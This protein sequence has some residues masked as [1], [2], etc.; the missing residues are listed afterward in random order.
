M[1][2]LRL[3]VMDIMH[4]FAVFLAPDEVYSYR[5]NPTLLYTSQRIIGAQSVQ[6]LCP[7]NALTNV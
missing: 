2:E 4:Q 1:F 7:D 6:K 3:I 5:M